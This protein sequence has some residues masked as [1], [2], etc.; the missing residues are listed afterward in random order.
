[1]IAVMGAIVPAAPT[2]TFGDAAG[3]NGDAVTG[4]DDANREF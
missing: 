2:R 3:Y 1:M 4:N